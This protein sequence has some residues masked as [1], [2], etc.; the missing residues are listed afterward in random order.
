M[1]ETLKLS[2]RDFAIAPRQQTMAPVNGGAQHGLSLDPWGDKFVCS[3]SDHLQQVLLPGTGRGRAT[4]YSQTPSLRRSIALDGPQADVFRISPVEPWR[5]LRTHM[6]V[7]GA[8]GGPIEGGGRAAGYFTGATGVYYY[9]GDQWPQS[10]T[11]LALVCDVGSN[12]VHR[13]RL[14]DDGLWKQGERIDAGSEFV[15]SRDVWFRPAQLGTGPDGALYIADMYREVIE[16]PKSLPPVIKSQLDLNSGNHRGRIWR[17]VAE[18]QPLRRKAPAMDTMATPELVKMVDH[19]NAWHRRT[20]ARLLFER[21]DRAAIDPLRVVVRGG[22]Y[23]A[24]RLQALASLAGMS[25]SEPAVDDAT[26]QAGLRD[27]H[28]RVR[29]QAIKV[30]VRTLGPQ[31]DL[32]RFSALW[33][34]LADD[35]SIF[36]RF[37]LAYE[38]LT[39][40]PESDSRSEVLAQI[41]AH[42]PADPWIRW[43]VEGSLGKAALPFAQKLGTQLADRED[44]DVTPWMRSV[45]C[46]LLYAEGNQGPAQIVAMLEPLDNQAPSQQI[47]DALF[48]AAV[49]DQLEGLPINDRTEPLADWVKQSLLPRVQETLASAKDAAGLSPPELRL[50]RWAVP[51]QVTPLLK[52]MM[53]PSE[54]PQVQQ[55]A[56]QELAGHD[57]AAS[58]WVMDHLS[59]LTPMMRG[60]A[61]QSLAERAAGLQAIATAIVDGSLRGD[62]LSEAVLRPLRNYPDPQL[63]GKVADKLAAIPTSVPAAQMATYQEALAAPADREAGQQIFRK[64]CV[65]CHRMG[66][67]G[68][69]VGPDLRSLTTKSPSQILLSILDPNAEVDPK[70]HTV[71][72][73]TNYGRVVSGILESETANSLRILSEK[74]EATVIPRED[75]ESLQTSNRSLMPTDVAKEISPAQ[76]ND[77]IAF[78]RAPQAST[79]AEK[80]EGAE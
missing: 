34:A 7:S 56:L 53:Q 58:Q 54:S 65:N 22:E 61:L 64:T 69:P 47:D 70:Y 11:P 10:E 35:P 42:D 23:P 15:R 59:Q 8:V 37:Q 25:G 2:R 78:L 3:N 33:Q 19:P 57:Q 72:V 62:A 28:P 45:V 68:K 40:L 67:L 20:A 32:S 21:Q 1:D 77:L 63:R 60:L 17:V 55:L 41:A 12:L 80:T 31:E 50:V 24:G 27:P 14:L 16:H 18:D 9:D 4:R 29:Q 75:I 30:A 43:A 44:A 49:A 66:T 6:R 52:Q 46:Q 71:Q 39:L 5:I 48:R 76:M 74:A 36:V 73:V 26:L 13:K 51:D 79:L 38:A